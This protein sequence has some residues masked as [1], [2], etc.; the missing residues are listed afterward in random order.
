MLPL[1]LANFARLASANTARKVG[2]SA[3]RSGIT[4]NRFDK[5]GK[6]IGRSKL[7][8]QEEGEGQ[9]AVTKQ[10]L[11]SF[12]KAVDGVSSAI[13]NKFMPLVLSVLP[14]GLDA[15]VGAVDKVKNAFLDR[16]KE[17]ARYSPEIQAAHAYS[18]QKNI[19]ADVE[20][21]KELG[22][23]LG[24]LEKANTDV[25]LELRDATLAIK[26]WLLSNL[27]DLFEWLKGAIRDARIA[28]AELLVRLDR[29]P[30][31]IGLY[32]APRNTK[33]ER[34][35]YEAKT[36][37]DVKKA[38]DA[39]N[40]AKPPVD[41]LGDAIEKARNRIRPANPNVRQPDRDGQ[42]L[43]IPGVQF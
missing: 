41:L 5:A 26:K 39:I 4:K 22:P 12:N 32:V 19:Q 14:A 18:Y 8:D 31:L 40:A 28:G 7:T 17:L 24:R 10:I 25:Q 15:L 20:E 37:V 9:G 33:A 2:F 1:L 30:H 16:A 3:A 43:R 42:R 21:A 38:I 35:A 27:A 6:S 23:D 11:A 34:E 36:E 13:N 29:M